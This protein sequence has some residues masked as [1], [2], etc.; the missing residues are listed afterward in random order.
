M[1]NALNWFEI[2]ATNIERAVKFY[3]AIL[4]VDIPIG[5]AM[6]GYKMAM[7]P[8]EG[9]VGG[10]ILQGEGYTPS[11]SGSVVYLN[12]GDDLGQILA[13]V[14]PAGG[15]VLMAKMNIG[16]YGFVGFFADSEGN[17]VGLHSLT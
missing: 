3:S 10:A 13:K 14:E 17:K 5:E 11:M 2:P 6:S 8:I 7:F 15:Q 16:Q 1:I 12:G 9:G 4:G